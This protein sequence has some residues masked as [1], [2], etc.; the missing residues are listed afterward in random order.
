VSAFALVHSPLVGASTWRWAAQELEA[1]G[2]RVTVPQV[3]AA[4]T[5][6]GWMAFADAV[7]G[8]ISGAEVLVGHSGAGPLLPQIVERAA[9]RPSALVFVDAAVPPPAGAAELMPLGMLAELRQ[10]ASD[11]R[12]PAWSD[13]F[14]PGVMDELVPDEGKRVAVL[15]ELPM[16][17]LSFFE[18]RVPLPAGWTGIP[19]GYVLLSE[20]YAAAADEADSR[21]WPVARSMGAHLDIVTRPKAVAEAI[22]AVTASFRAG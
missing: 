14:G 3:P 11:G 17:P 19:S 15:A 12:L 9:G 8:Q 21:G 7:A 10:L 20:A 5:A 22:A 4:V 18:D 2:H 1:A 16:L 13:W 6:Q